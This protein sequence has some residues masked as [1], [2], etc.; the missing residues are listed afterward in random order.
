VA[1]AV[2]SYLVARPLLTAPYRRL[3][4]WAIALT[5]VH[6]LLAGNF[7]VWAGS[8]ASIVDLPSSTTVLLVLV[9][10][11]AIVGLAVVIRPAR[12]LIRTA[13]VPQVEK[14]ARERRAL[15]TGSG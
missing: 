3:A 9:V 10:A 5:A 4:V 2:A 15:T 1:V 6:V 11:A 14:A 13:V 12:R 7:L 8:K